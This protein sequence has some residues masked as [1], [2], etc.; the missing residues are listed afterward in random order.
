M[1]IG[2]QEGVSR[3]EFV[4]KGDS[5][6]A[7][8]GIASKLLSFAS[9]DPGESDTKVYEYRPPTSFQLPNLID[10]PSDTVNTIRFI[11]S[12]FIFTSY[13][14]FNA[15]NNNNFNN[16]LEFSEHIG[17][18]KSTG[19]FIEV[20][21]FMN[22]S[23]YYIPAGKANVLINDQPIPTQEEEENKFEHFPSSIH[24]SYQTAINGT[25]KGGLCIIPI[26][27]LPSVTCQK[28]RKAFKKDDKKKTISETYLLTITNLEKNGAVVVEDSFLRTKNWELDI[29]KTKPDNFELFGQY[30]ARWSFPNIA[31]GET[32]EVR[33]TVNYSWGSDIPLEDSSLEKSVVESKDEQKQTPQDDDKQPAVHSTSFF[34][35]L[36]N[37]RR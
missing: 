14:L 5:N 27:S 22:E 6:Y 15:N 2:D 21:S 34:S 36:L 20:I 37:K 35:K 23:N 24:K 1:T 26:R 4:L 11:D 13:F 25:S 10:L 28:E 9:Y 3:G 33:Y 32:V 31:V 18:R 16:Q 29:T 17:S 19:N 12:N 30:S 7:T 8:S